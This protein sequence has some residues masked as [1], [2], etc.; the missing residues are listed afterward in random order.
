[1]IMAK[2]GESNMFL[3]K[4]CPVCG[5]IF[6]F[7]VLHAYKDKRSPYSKV[8]SWKCVCESERLKEA[9]MKRKT[10]KR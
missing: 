9:A 10:R 1:M 6:L 4:K 7:T 8:C 3:E 2:K 5:K